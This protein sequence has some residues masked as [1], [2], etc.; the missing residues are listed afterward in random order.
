MNLIAD[1]LKPKW[2]FLLLLFCGSL[3]IFSLH[4]CKK[5][6]DPNELPGIALRMGTDY[7]STDFPANKNQSFKVGIIATGADANDTLVRFT[8]HIS[9]NGQKDSTLI[10]EIIP[11]SSRYSYSRD[12]QLITGKTAGEEKYIFIV[13]NKNGKSK[14]ISLRA[15]VN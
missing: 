4:S 8:A 14:G 2:S 6:D 12:I 5:G 10:D 1:M 3:N 15:F 11:P 9:V 13:H 7:T